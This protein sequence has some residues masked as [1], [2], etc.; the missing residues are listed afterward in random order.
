MKKLSWLL[1][2]LLLLTAGAGLL[3][4]CQTTDAGG[5]SGQQKEDRRHHYGQ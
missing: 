4:G 2:L 5:Y 3:S 1:A